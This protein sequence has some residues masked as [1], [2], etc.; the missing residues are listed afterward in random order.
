MHFISFVLGTVRAHPLWVVAISRRPNKCIDISEAMFT[1]LHA[2]IIKDFCGTHLLHAQ[3][4]VHTLT[5]SKIY[6]RLCTTTA[7]TTSTATT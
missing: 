5:N 1:Y 2:C 7:T 3:V 4:V 6:C